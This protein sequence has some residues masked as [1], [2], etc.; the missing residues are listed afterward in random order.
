MEFLILKEQLIFKTNNGKASYSFQAIGAA[1]FNA[2][3]TGN[4]SFLNNMIGIYKVDMIEGGDDVFTM[5][6]W[7]SPEP[8]RLTPD[9]PGE[10][11]LYL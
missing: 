6:N 11:S 1:F 5:W 9:F 4:L 7:R 2:N 3:A 8:K 10:M